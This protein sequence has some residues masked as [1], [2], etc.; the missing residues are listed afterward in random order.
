MHL[1]MPRG[2]NTRHPELVEGSVRL[3]L[4]E[5]ELIDNSSTSL[6]ARLA[7]AAGEE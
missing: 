4:T 6:R 1:Q 5:A 2:K 3:P 7:A